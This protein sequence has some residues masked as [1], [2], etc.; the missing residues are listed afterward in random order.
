MSAAA[1]SCL[2]YWQLDTGAV[3]PSGGDQALQRPHNTPPHTHCWCGP[4]SGDK[5]S[6]PSQTQAGPGKGPG[7][8]T[9]WKRGRVSHSPL[10]AELSWVP[11]APRHASDHKHRGGGEQ[12]LFLEFSKA[13]DFS[14]LGQPLAPVPP[15]PSRATVSS[16]QAP[17]TD[18]EAPPPIPSQPPLPPIHSGLGTAC[19]RGA[20]VTSPSCVSVPSSKPWGRW[21]TDIHGPERTPR[22]RYEVKVCISFASEGLCGACPGV[23]EIG[24]SY[25]Q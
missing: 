13:G 25:Q 5:P 19:N 20:L 21:S 8:R 18:S 1:G 6:E 11:K 22:L 9:C 14:V 12:N 4:A 3:L 7:C 23:F 2:D 10:E 15:A 17:P 24:I 16:T